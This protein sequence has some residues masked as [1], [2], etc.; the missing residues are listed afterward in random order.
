MGYL[1]ETHKKLPVLFTCL[2]GFIDETAKVS[3]STVKNTTKWGPG[4][5]DRH[6]QMASQATEL[7]GDSV[8]VADVVSLP[9]FIPMEAVDYTNV[10][11]TLTAL[12]IVDTRTNR[13]GMPGKGSLMEQIH[14]HYS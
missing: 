12:S 14:F 4:K 10:P 11:A 2:N 3:I 6:D 5:G 13:A 9:V 1:R 8:P 7:S